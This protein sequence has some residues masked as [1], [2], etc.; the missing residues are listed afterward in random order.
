[1]NDTYLNYY[2]VWNLKLLHKEPQIWCFH[3]VTV[4]EKTLKKKL[5]INKY[6]LYFFKVDFTG[7]A[8]WGGSISCVYRNSSIHISGE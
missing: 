3:I 4:L 7:G 8:T 6:T 5:K 1:M 2:N